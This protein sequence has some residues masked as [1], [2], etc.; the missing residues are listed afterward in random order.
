[1][2][3]ELEDD[4]DGSGPS[5]L[6]RLLRCIAALALTTLEGIRLLTPERTAA[7]GPAQTLPPVIPLE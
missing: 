4:D 5:D 6:K 1:M 3:Q 7:N 2:V